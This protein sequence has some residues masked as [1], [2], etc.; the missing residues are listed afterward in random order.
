MPF[1]FSISLSCSVIRFYW[2]NRNRFHG[3]LNTVWWPVGEELQLHVWAWGASC[4]AR[5]IK[6]ITVFISQSWG[7]WGHHSSGALLGLPKQQFQMEMQN[8]RVG[9]NQPAANCEISPWPGRT[10]QFLSRALCRNSRRV[11]RCLQRAALMTV[12]SRRKP[13][14]LDHRG[15]RSIPAF[16]LLVSLTT[17]GKLFKTFCFLRL[18]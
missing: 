11:M 6:V 5:V 17:F 18:F 13:L 15:L 7:G 2:L 4:K 3:Y 12:E 1:F 10:A 8:V 16:S 9:T 14:P